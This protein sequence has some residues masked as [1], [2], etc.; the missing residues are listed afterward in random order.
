MSYIKLIAAI[1]Q[2]VILISFL[3]NNAINFTLC[4]IDFK[5]KKKKNWW[6]VLIFPVA[7]FPFPQKATSKA[8]TK[9]YAEIF[10]IGNCFLLLL[11][12][13]SLI[14]LNYICHLIIF[15]G[16]ITKLI[17]TSIVDTNYNFLSNNF[18]GIKTSEKWL[19][20]FECLRNKVNNN[21]FITGKKLVV[22][23]Q[24]KMERQ[25]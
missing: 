4:I 23:R 18:T 14:F 7:D 22:K 24:T 20:L 16:S 11:T 21:H 2:S 19:K 17:V 8:I 5:T 10:F 6:K 25:F 12:I 13:L 15:F 9:R 1:P 3:K